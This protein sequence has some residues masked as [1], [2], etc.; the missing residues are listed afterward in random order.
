M[1]V[2]F[3]VSVNRTV[4]NI[5]IGPGTDK[6]QCSVGSDSRS[7][8]YFHF[9]VPRQVGHLGY[10]ICI[11]IDHAKNSDAA[12]VVPARSRIIYTFAVRGDSGGRA[13][14]S[15]FKVYVIRRVRVCFPVRMISLN[16]RQ[17][18]EAKLAVRAG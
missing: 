9:H 18:S 14:Y 8:R 10:E 12:A 15:D 1:A 7:V 6:Q 3:N 13:G 11:T 4:E 16:C 5:N 2:V 17:N